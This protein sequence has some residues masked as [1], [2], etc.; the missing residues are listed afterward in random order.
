MKLRFSLAPLIGLALAGFPIHSYASISGVWSNP[1]LAG[2]LVDGLTNVPSF[3]N[4]NGTAVVTISGGTITFGD[5][6]DL[7]GVHDPVVCANFAAAGGSC[8]SSLTF[9][10]ASSIPAVQDATHPF[11]LGTM[12]FKNGSSSLGTGI[13]GATLTLFESGSPNPI[14]SEFVF[15]GTTINDGTVRQNADYIT[16]SGL[17][18]QS[19]NTLEGKTSVMGLDGFID[20]VVLTGITAQDPNGFVGDSPTFAVPEPASIA[21]LGTGLVGFGVIRRRRKTACFAVSAEFSPMKRGAIT[22]FLLFMVIAFGAQVPASAAYTFASI[23]DPS[24]AT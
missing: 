10:G 5:A 20:D 18:G 16:F 2:F 11:Q 13:F 9:T 22:V 8:F 17:A 3:N 1:V 6:V 24:A 12:T 15:I 23:D 14:G 21:L 7:Q 19:F 4:D